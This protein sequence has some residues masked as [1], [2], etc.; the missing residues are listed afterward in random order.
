MLKECFGRQRGI[1][2]R[3]NNPAVYQFGNKDNITIMQR[4]IFNFSGKT[5]CKCNSKRNVSCDYVYNQLFP[6]RKAK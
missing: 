6:K 5:K 3:K 2:R 4:S 1:G